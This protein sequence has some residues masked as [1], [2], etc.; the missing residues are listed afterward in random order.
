MKLAYVSLVD[1]AEPSGAVDHILGIAR[2]LAELGHEV[3]LVAPTGHAPVPTGPSGRLTLHLVSN[4]R[5]LPAI[6]L[7]LAHEARRVL[8]AVDVE[9]VYLRNFPLDYW[10]IAN[11]LND[12]G[13]P[14]VCELNTMPDAEY[15]ARG[16]KWAAKVY[17]DATRRTL[18]GARGWLPISYEI[19]EWSERVAGPRK[20]FAI[21]RNG[22]TLEGLT[23]ARS[24]AEVR[25][26]LGVAETTAV[27]V[28][29]GFT[30]PWQGGDRAIAMMAHMPGKAELWLIGARDEADHA[31]ALATA[32]EHGVEGAVRVLPWMPQLEAA[33]FVAAADVALGSLA[34]DRNLMAEGQSIKVPFCLAMG[35]PVLINYRDVRLNDGQAFVRRVEGHDPHKLAMAAAELLRV[36][37]DPAAIRAYVEANLTWGASAKA[38]EPL[39]KDAFARSAPHATRLKAS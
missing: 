17:S 33:T 20:P 27:L 12:R 30:A 26:A 31:A 18:A 39:L 36:Q 2:G 35:V 10:L 9:G 5:P 34:L 11:H 14:Y 25:A 13:I 16:K 21:A 4:A 7:R 23:P 6:A 28:M 8:R 1:L 37:Q 19:Q 22:I 38:T 29:S 15:R 3:H 32:R 24:R